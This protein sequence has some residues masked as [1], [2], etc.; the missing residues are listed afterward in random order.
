MKIISTVF[1]ICIAFYVI[2]LISIL[3]SCTT[4]ETP[5]ISNQVLANNVWEVTYFFDKDKDETTDFAGY[6]FTFSDQGVATATNGSTSKTGTWSKI[7]DDGFQKLVIN[8]G[9]GK[10]LEE[11]NDDWI[12]QE[13][14]T[15]FMKL[16]D[17]N[18]T[19]LEELHFQA[20]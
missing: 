14:S 13:E 18:D 16:M 17:D 10:P 12:I 1:K 2:V 9:I 11:L 19:H 6:S 4:E 7:S 5:D 15:S 8:F 3:S 20:K